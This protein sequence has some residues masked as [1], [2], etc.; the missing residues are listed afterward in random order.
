MSRANGE[1]ILRGRLA[2]PRRGHSLVPALLVLQVVAEEI[3]ARSKRAGEA[4]RWITVHDR[5]RGR[6]VRRRQ[7][8][9]T[10]FPQDRQ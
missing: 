2:G 4:G 10:L 7:T 6:P 9:Q 5:D 1:R 8:V 3:T